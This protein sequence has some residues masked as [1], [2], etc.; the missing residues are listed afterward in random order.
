MI[1]RIVVGITG[2]SGAIYGVRI[3]R[4]LEPWFD[5]VYLCVSHHGREVLATELGLQ[6]DNA[7]A[8]VCGLLGRE[9]DRIEVLDPEDY[10]TPPASGSVHHEG[11]VIAPCSM[12]TAGRIASGVSTDL[13]TRAADVCLKERRRLVLVVRETPLSVVHLRNLTALAEAGAVIMPA[14]PSF[15]HHPRTVEEMV[16]TVVA[17][18]AR[19]LGVGDSESREWQVE[20]E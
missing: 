6:A 19:H 14:S 3:V 16:D 17:R 10:F 11:M 13:I 4:M 9:S 8:L 18:A 15:Y 12:G 1:R 5:V 7:E 2:A 20:R